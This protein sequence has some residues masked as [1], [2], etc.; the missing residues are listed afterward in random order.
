MKT[1]LTLDDAAFLWDFH[2]DKDKYQVESMVIGADYIYH[3]GMYPESAYHAWVFIPKDP[4]WG[5][6]HRDIQAKLD[7]TYVEPTASV[8]T[9]DL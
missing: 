2:K 3:P 4:S 9:A 5:Q 6:L 8:Q 1:T 7:G